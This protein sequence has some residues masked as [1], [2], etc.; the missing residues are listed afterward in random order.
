[1]N[2]L[3]IDGTGGPPPISVVCDST[4]K[5]GV[6]EIKDSNGVT[7]KQINFGPGNGPFALSWNGTNPDGTPVPAGTYSLKVTTTA[8]DGTAV[9]ATPEISGTATKLE[10]DSDGNYLRIGNALVTPAEVISIG[11]STTGASS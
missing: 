6:M 1:M 4:I 9:N 5:S 2:S 7:V 3:K 8:A 11:G 10:L